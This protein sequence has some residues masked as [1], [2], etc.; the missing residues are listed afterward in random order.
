MGLVMFLSSEEREALKYQ[1]LQLSFTVVT[2]QGYMNRFPTPHCFV[3]KIDLLCSE[4][5]KS[6]RCYGLLV[7]PVRLDCCIMILV[8]RTVEIHESPARLTL[9][10]I[11]V[12][13]FEISERPWFESDPAASTIVRYTLL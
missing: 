13:R 10:W 3:F 8:F 9:G 2:V 7:S 12:L 5:Q 11:P 4:Y 1:K 6:K